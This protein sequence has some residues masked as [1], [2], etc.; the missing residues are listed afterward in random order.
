MTPLNVT[1]RIASTEAASPQLAQDLL[2]LARVAKLDVY[3]D[4]DTPERR[5]EACQ[6]L[7]QAAA[8]LVQLDLSSLSDRAVA[9]AFWINLYN[10]LVIHGALALG[11]ARSM[12]EVSDF[13]SRAAY[14]VGGL[15]FNLDVIEHGLLRDNRGHP[16]RVVLPQLSPFDPRRKLVIKPMDLRV[17]FALNCG[18]ASCPPIRHYTPEQLDGQLDMAARSFVLG[19]GARVDADSGRVVLSKIFRWYAR[20]FGLRRASQVEAALQFVDDPEEAARL[21]AA[22][23]VGVEYAD[24]DW[25]I[26]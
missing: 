8:P 21:R 5:R 3:Q 10:A 15:D 7:A 6:R 17:H 24:Y 23:E 2:D 11:V 16:S 22:A 13:F 20:D 25:T 14:R 4:R 9:L 18:A 26:A 1:D 12:E 19:G